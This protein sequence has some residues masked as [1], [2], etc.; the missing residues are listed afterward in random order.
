MTNDRADSDREALDLLIRGFQVSRML[1]LVAD[2]AVADKIPRDGSRNVSDLATACSVLA[3][4]LLR[5]LR[6][7][8][9]SGVFRVGADGG[10]AHSPRS[11]LLR[12]DEPNSLHHG[13][14]FWTAP[15]SWKAWGVL[16]TALAGSDPNQA[17]WGMDRFQYL[18]EHP[19]EARIF[20][21]FMANF[22]DRRHQTLA[23]S[24]DFS[25][26]KLI[27]DVGGGNAEALRQIL[28]RFPGPRGI[29]FDRDDVVA[30]IPPEARL[31]GR[32]E[33]QG[34][35][36]FD[37]V[38]QGA[39]IYL[40][41]RVLHNWSDDDCIRIL[42]NCRCAMRPNARLLVVEQ[43]IEPDPAL[44]RPSGYLVDTHM[45][46]MFGAARERTRPE[47]GELLQS[48][49]FALERVIETASPVWVMEAVPG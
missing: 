9:A 43:I 3:T 23:V 18:R 35:S 7:L 32:I 19:A 10:V 47:F 27:V 33:V 31:A 13:A 41:I 6:A 4:P 30:A 48:S 39:D 12:T 11:M 44:G 5:I 16:D 38:P 8:A 28:E 49:G 42:R 45:M 36:F 46:A 15:G 17:A 14:R 37:R 24:Y 25:G 34:G 40:V 29:V 1:R 20:D 2:L 22:P 21:A 26:A